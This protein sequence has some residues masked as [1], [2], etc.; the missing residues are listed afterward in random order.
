MKKKINKFIYSE[1]ITAIFSLI[2]GILLIIAPEISLEILSYIVATM[3][4]LNG[5]ILLV[6]DYKLG[7]YLVLFENTVSAT[8]SIVLGIL[9]LLN[10]KSIT[11]FIP[12]VFGIWF[13]ITSIFKCKLA[14][15]LGDDNKYLS[16]IISILT[17]ICGILLIIRPYSGAITLAFITG[18]VLITYSVMDIIDTIIL[19]KN[20]DTIS[21]EIKKV[22]DFKEL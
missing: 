13:I 12:I 2:I 22:F 21:K 7:R 3:L 20:I 6:L 1:I 18:I 10:P 5:I 19:K 17:M 15:L 8:L 9:V 14:L 16:V 11:I 4:L